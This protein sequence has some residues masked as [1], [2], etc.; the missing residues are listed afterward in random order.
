MGEFLVCADVDEIVVRASA[1]NVPKKKTDFF[2]K[3]VNKELTKVIL[4]QR[5]QKVSIVIYFYSKLAIFGVQNLINSKTF[6]KFSGSYFIRKFI[7]TLLKT[8]TFMS[9]MKAREYILLQQSSC[10]LETKTPA[11]AGEVYNLKFR[12]LSEY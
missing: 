9:K 7:F 10:K 11:K 2:I 1:K 4:C 3:E 8:S 5:V 12:I 6:G